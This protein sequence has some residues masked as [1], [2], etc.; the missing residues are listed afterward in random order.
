[1]PRAF[2]SSKF[3]RNPLPGYHGCPSGPSQHLMPFLS[4]AGF[5][6]CATELS[7]PPGSPTSSCFSFCSAASRWQLRI[8][9]GPSPSATRCLCSCGGLGW[10]GEVSA[11]QEAETCL[12]DFM[13]EQVAVISS[14]PLGGQYTLGGEA[15]CVFHSGHSWDKFLLPHISVISGEEIHLTGCVKLPWFKTCGG[16]LRVGTSCEV[17]NWTTAVCSTLKCCWHGAVIATGLA[18][19]GTNGSAPVQCLAGTGGSHMRQL[20]RALSAFGDQMLSGESGQASLGN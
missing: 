10:V 4:L 11:P 9:S 14:L 8:P 17:A 15:G 16:L 3:S 13:P 19:R 7:T 6:C 18:T 5:G 20:P 1:M 12:P 2:L